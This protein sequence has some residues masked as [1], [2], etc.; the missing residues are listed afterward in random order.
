MEEEWKG[1][2]GRVGIGV[3]GKMRG[4]REGEG[5]R[6]NSKD[7]NA[8]VQAGCAFATKQRTVGLARVER[9]ML[10][11]ALPLY[12]CIRSHVSFSKP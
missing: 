5:R 8:V 10:P 1:G 4:C 7:A 9:M 3:G 2:V 12:M 11:H 6:D